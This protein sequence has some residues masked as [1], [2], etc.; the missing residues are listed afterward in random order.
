MTT[1]LCSI[2]AFDNTCVFWC[3]EL[4]SC[5]FK[6]DNNLKSNKVTYSKTLAAAHTEKGSKSL[7]VCKDGAEEKTC[8]HRSMASLT[9]SHLSPF[10]FTD[11]YL[12]YLST[13]TNPKH[14]HVTQDL[15]SC[16][17]I[18]MVANFMERKKV[19][20]H[21]RSAVTISTVTEFHFPNFT[22]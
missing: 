18:S 10:P 14:Q 11:I 3:R 9:S 17:C 8:A 20:W 19:W 2:R 5:S 12:L 4:I 22:S 15:A 6:N 13:M 16:V 21:P 7:S 1:S